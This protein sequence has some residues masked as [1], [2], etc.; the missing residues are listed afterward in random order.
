[1]MNFQPNLPM[2]RENVPRNE[3]PSRDLSAENLF[4]FTTHSRTFNMLWTPPPPGA[5]NFYKRNEKVAQSGFFHRIAER[6]ISSC[7][8]IRFL[9]RL[10]ITQNYLRKE[11]QFHMFANMF[12]WYQL[13]TAFVLIDHSCFQADAIINSLIENERLEELGLLVVDEVRIKNLTFPRIF[14]PL[15]LDLWYAFC[16]Y[17]LPKNL[18][19]F[20]K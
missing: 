20:Q 16:W 11:I 14:W 5:S 2:Y 4:R 17:P 6:C 19:G 1:M 12:L 9:M 8:G 3:P 15:Q 13:Q 18:Q 10:A 7:N